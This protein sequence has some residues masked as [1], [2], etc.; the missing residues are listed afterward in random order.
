M[1]KVERIFLQFVL[2]NSE[3]RRRKEGGDPQIFP[4][5][6][7]P[8][9]P[10]IAPLTLYHVIVSKSDLSQIVTPRKWW[11]EHKKTAAHRYTSKR[12]QLHLS[13]TKQRTFEPIYKEAFSSYAST[14]PTL[15]A[16]LVTSIISHYCRFFRIAISSDISHFAIN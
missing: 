14:T 4:K 8:P 15:N 7:N 6:R 9:R 10:P 1:R 13:A 12:N 2:K 5:R 11:G 3:K 16:Q